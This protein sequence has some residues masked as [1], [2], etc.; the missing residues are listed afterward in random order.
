MVSK[1]PCRERLRSGF[2]CRGKL[3]LPSPWHRRWS[4]NGEICGECSRSYCCCGY[5]NRL[6]SPAAISGMLPST[7]TSRSG[8]RKPYKWRY[9][10]GL[11]H[12][13]CCYRCYST[14]LSSGAFSWFLLHQHRLQVLEILNMR[15]RIFKLFSYVDCLASYEF[16]ST[17]YRYIVKPWIW[18][19]LCWSHVSLT[20]MRSSSYFPANSSSSRGPRA[21]NPAF[22]NAICKEFA[23]TELSPIS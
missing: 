14:R 19:F 1:V 12:L 13:R 18:G 2:V 5:V 9:S 15:G 4:F 23:M 11:G 7:R 8:H 10:M 17:V 22:Q 16:V 21:E 3:V 20:R 6:K